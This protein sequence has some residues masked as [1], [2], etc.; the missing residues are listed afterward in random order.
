MVLRVNFTEILVSLKL[1]SSKKYMNKNAKL[2]T[3]DK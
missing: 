1:A 2:A 3:I